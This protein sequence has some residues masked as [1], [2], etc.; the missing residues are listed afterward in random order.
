MSP[1]SRRPVNIFL[2]QACAVSALPVPLSAMLTPRWP[3]AF[4]KMAASLS[5]AGSEGGGTGTRRVWGSNWSERR[6]SRCPDDLGG[7]WARWWSDPA[8][9][10]DPQR[11]GSL[12]QGDSQLIQDWLDAAWATHPR[13]WLGTQTHTHTQTDKYK[14]V[15]QK[16]WW[17]N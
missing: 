1:E 10:S 12:I 3:S 9:G 6:P 17:L 14:F 5:E 13:H 2:R 16:T 15:L 11:T 7:A 4:L 8:P